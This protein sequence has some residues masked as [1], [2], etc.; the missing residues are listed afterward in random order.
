MPMVKLYGAEDAIEA[1]DAG[2]QRRE[3]HARQAIGASAA[4][5]RWNQG[6]QFAKMPRCCPSRPTSPAAGCSA[7]PDRKSTRLTSRH[8][9]T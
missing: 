7:A 6:L 3:G 9:Q 5:P 1:V 2:L 4:R 8:D